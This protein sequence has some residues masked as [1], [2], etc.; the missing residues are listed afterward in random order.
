[1]HKRNLVSRFKYF[2]FCVKLTLINFRL[3]KYNNYVV[4]RQ[5]R[6]H[7]LALVMSLTIINLATNLNYKPANLTITL[8]MSYHIIKQNNLIPNANNTN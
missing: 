3:Q 2:I 1:M 5:Y 6:P 4:K 8:K 7:R